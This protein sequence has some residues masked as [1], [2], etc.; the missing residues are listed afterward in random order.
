[1]KRGEIW[2]ADLPG[3]I[4][5]RPVLLISRDEAYQVR[6]NILVIPLTRTIRGFAVEVVVGKE[7]GVP[8]RSV[9]NTDTVITIPKRLLKQYMTTLSGLKMIEVEEAVKF[10]LGI[11]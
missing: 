8:T 6:A 10:S 5:R 1:M 3:P 9:I 4:G 2:W 7:E 11:E